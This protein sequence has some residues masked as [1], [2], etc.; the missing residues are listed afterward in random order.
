MALWGTQHEESGVWGRIE[1]MSWA[2]AEPQSTGAV[3]VPFYPPKA[4]LTN[5]QGLA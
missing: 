1:S 2:Q 5:P 4:F 3:C